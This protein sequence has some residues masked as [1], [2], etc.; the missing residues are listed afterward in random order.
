MLSL[1][2]EHLAE[3]CFTETIILQYWYQKGTFT[4][5]IFIME[6]VIAIFCVS[7]IILNMMF[8]VPN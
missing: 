2:V 6:L 5:R 1:S 8:E 3:N 4:Y 7:T